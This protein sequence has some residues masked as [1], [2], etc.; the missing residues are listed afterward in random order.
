M[1]RA[2]DIAAIGL[3][4]NVFSYDEVLSQDSNLSPPQQRTDAQRV[5]PRS[6]NKIYIQPLQP[7]C[8]TQPEQPL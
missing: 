3:K 4:F 7:S 5:D 1:S 2:P 8:I 6:G